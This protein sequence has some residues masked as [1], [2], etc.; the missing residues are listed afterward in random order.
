MISQT[1]V[2]FLDVKAKQPILAESS[3]V[4]EPLKVCARLAEE[5]KLHLLKL[6]NTE[7]KVT[8]SDLVSE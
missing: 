3:P 8:R 1:K 7:N 2:F 4:V 5:L 6:T